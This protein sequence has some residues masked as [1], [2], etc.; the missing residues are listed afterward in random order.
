MV[1][2]CVSEILVIVL[3]REHSLYAGAPV[4]CEDVE[5]GDD[6][7]WDSAQAVARG[8]DQDVD[9]PVAG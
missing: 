1:L 2:L 4:A 8:C 5:G 6:L 9:S 7:V 3:L